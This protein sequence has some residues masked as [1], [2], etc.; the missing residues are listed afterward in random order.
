MRLKVWN[1][2]NGTLEF[3]VGTAVLFESRILCVPLFY[4]ETA[5]KN[6]CKANWRYR[7]VGNAG[8]RIIDC[9]C[10]SW[11]SCVVLQNPLSFY[12]LFID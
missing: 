9:C 4:V 7:E 12:L 6:P 3:S 8:S 10:W 11:E 5:A 2:L 1:T